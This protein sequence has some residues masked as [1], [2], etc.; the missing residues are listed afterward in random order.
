M[1]QTEAGNTTKTK[2]TQEQQTASH[3]VQERTEHSFGTLFQKA[4]AHS[5]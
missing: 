2:L 1:L 4:H 5:R 3:E